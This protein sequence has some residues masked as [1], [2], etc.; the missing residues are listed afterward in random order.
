MSKKNKINKKVTRYQRETVSEKVITAA[1]YKKLQKFL[2]GVHDLLAIEIKT[3]TFSTQH[4]L[5]YTLN[6]IIMLI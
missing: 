2:Y 5:T 6:K 3:V 1:S 4:P